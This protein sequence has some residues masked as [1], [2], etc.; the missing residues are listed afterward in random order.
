MSTNP[1]DIARK[2]ANLTKS[3]TDTDK[4]IAQSSAGSVRQD[5]GSTTLQ[6]AR[7]GKRPEYRNN[8]GD[9]RTDRAAS[10]AGAGASEASSSASGSER[11]D[12]SAGGEPDKQPD[13]DDNFVSYSQTKPTYEPVNAEPSTPERPKSQ[14]SYNA[15]PS[16]T[17]PS[18]RRIFNP[19]NIQ[20]PVRVHSRGVE[21]NA[22]SA[23][24]TNRVPSTSSRNTDREFG[25][26]LPELTE[27]QRQLLDELVE[28]NGQDSYDSI[29]AGI[30]KLKR[31][32]FLVLP[33]G[34]A[35]TSISAPANVVG[36]PIAHEGLAL[37]DW[38]NIYTLNKNVAP[39]GSDPATFAL[40]RMEAV[41]AGWVKDLRE[42]RFEQAPAGTEGLMNL[43]TDLA[44]IRDKAET[45]KTAA[46]L[47]PLV[48]EH[49]FRTM[50]HHFITSDQA[51]YVQRYTETLKSCLTPEVATLLPPATLFHAALHW[52]GPGRA[53]EVLMAQLES[54]AIPDALRIRANAAPAGT[55][56]LTTTAAIVDAMASVGL[57]AAFEQYGNFGLQVISAVTAEVKKSPVKYHKSYFAYGVPAPTAIEAS[58]LA[59]AKQLAERFAPYAQAFIDTYM[60][61]AA[62][63]RARAIRKH[64]EGN[65]IQL[66]R[67]ANLFRAITRTNVTSV[68]DLIRIKLTTNEN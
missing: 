8:D 62:L 65:P 9:A 67:A 1:E 21:S 4:K 45:L 6:Q 14:G 26:L 2:I 32:E 28:I 31:D 25:V 24:A 35:I 33:A 57:D 50:G 11:A 64:A 49:T 17:G 29:T 46:F 52:V 10:T 54:P 27:S 3:I 37:T 61:E 56:I 55:A 22:A 7:A 16:T 51:S 60:R 66:R 36:K 68:E 40:L 20:E 19:R 44:Q 34:I 42:V 23:Q 15:P 63:G 41:K 59:A 30:G 39:A 18:G 53:R 48:A 5:V 43:V 12:S 38:G 58:N 13:N 47:L